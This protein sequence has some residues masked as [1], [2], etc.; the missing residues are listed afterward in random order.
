MQIPGLTQPGKF[1]KIDPSDKNSPLAKSFA[2]TTDQMDPLKSIKAMESAVRSSERVGTQTIDGV[3]TDHYK[4]TVDTAA[5]LGDRLKDIPAETRA[6]L[7]LPKTLTYDLWL[8]KQHLLRRTSFDMMGS[9]FEAT[10]SKWGEPVKIE[11]PAASQVTAM[12]G[13]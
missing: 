4:L 13:A 5:L 11:A 1:V 8:D 10:M 7:K 6:Q 2:G 12:P 3:S 9:H